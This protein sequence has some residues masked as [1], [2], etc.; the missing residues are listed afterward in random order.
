MCW[1]PAI[2]SAAFP[3][4]IKEIVIVSGINVVR[5]HIPTERGGG[6]RGSRQ[7]RQR[8]RGGRRSGW[9]DYF[10]APANERQ[11]ELPDQTALSTDTTSAFG[12]GRRGGERR[13][14]RR[15]GI[16]RRGG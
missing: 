6:W 1:R 5:G 3:Y 11:I 2:T 13:H 4:K 8:S 9:D 16:I 12:L 10:L 15:Q 14:R 7:C